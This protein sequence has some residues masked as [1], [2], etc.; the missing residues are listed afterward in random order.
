MPETQIDRG[1]P[2]FCRTVLAL[3]A[4]GFST[5]AVLYDTQPLLP[6]LANAFH[7]DPAVSSLS[8]SVTTGTLAPSLLFAG[9]LSDARGR[10]P[11]MVVAL[12]ISAVLTLLCAA[13][14]AWPA[15]LGLRA[16][17][18]V[19]LSGVPAVAMAY[20]AEEMA[21]GAVGFAMGLY[22][23]GNA[24]GGMSGR[25]LN[26]ILADLVSWRFA[27]AVTGVMALACAGILWRALPPSRH[28]QPRPM[29]L[30]AMPGQFAA[31]FRE[32]ALPWIYAEGFLLM[33]AFVTVYNYIPF[34]LLA[35]PYSLTQAEVGA[36]FVLYLVGIASSSLAGI[37]TPRFGRP[38]LLLGS[39]GV[40]FTGLVLTTMAPLW[41]IIAGIGLVTFGFFGAHSVASAGIGQRAGAAK[42]AASALYLLAYYVG[43]SVMGSIGGLF[44]SAGQWPGV[45]GFVAPLI[46]M[47]A[48]V[49]VRLRLIAGRRA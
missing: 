9:A 29:R 39:I 37:L 30:A 2:A 27:L 10:K 31:T 32:P 48:L 6:V 45:A 1:T 25:L 42:G 19:M 38:R 5:F 34:R 16:L 26:G 13:A 28:Y 36:I 35:P 8:L 47:A 40:M 49:G 14:P 3:L 20:V 7:V 22:I 11:L 44:W 21:P 4:A 46:I 41:L 15:L 18:G 24:L 12:V 23:S 43:S 17:Q 33:G